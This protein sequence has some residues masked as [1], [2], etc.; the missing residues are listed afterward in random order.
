VIKML[1]QL[2]KITPDSTLTPARGL[3]TAV[4]FL[5][6]LCVL[7][8]LG[9]TSVGSA[10]GLGLL[11]GVLFTSLCDIGGSV[12][13]RTVAMSALIIG[14]RSSWQRGA[15]CWFPGGWQR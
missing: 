14:G 6:A 5:L 11:L 3:R 12:S 9:H 15:H 13:V 2:F 4:A 1:Q 7:V 10:V 8:A